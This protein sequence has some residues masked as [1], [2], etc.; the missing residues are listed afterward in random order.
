VIGLDWQVEPQ[1]A[2][3]VVELSTTGDDNYE[4][5]AGANEVGH[6]VALQGNLDPAVLYSGH[7]AIEREVER[8]CKARKGG[9]GG[10]GAWIANLGHGV[11]PGV[12]PED[13][14]F[15]LKCVQTYSREGATQRDDE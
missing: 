14:R 6:R 10:H 12:D 15:M 1:V 11:T 9:F 3:K 8:M 2:R 5:G 13:L 4:E 7:D